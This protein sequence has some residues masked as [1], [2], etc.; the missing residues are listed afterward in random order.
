MP[1]VSLEQAS[2]ARVWASRRR[3]Q[4]GLLRTAGSFAQPLGS[5]IDPDGVAGYYVDMRGKAETE[6]WPPDW[7]CRHEEQEYVAVSQLGLGCYERF[8]GGEGDVWLDGALK[9]GD[10]LLSQQRPGGGWP[11][12][13]AYPHTYWV[14]PPWVSAMAQGEAASLL[15]RLHRETGE[16][17]YAEA[18]QL[19]LRPLWVATVN[20]GVRAE[21]DGGPFLEE[22]PTQPPS[23]ILN[24]T[25]FALWGCRDV[26]VAL[27][28]EDALELFREGHATLAR[29][30]H[31]WDTGY[32]SRYDLYPHP[33]V[34]LANPFY[35]QLHI[36]QLTAM[37]MIAPHRAFAEAHD[38]FEAYARSPVDFARA[39]A[40]KLAFRFVSPRSRRV[41]R[42]FPWARHPARSAVDQRA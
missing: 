32:W 40:S 42:W 26:G 20:G 17:R 38:R 22:T 11:H 36:T 16:D 25:L 21:L 6:R 13:W 23:L 2:R 19:A 31:R 15:V 24:G 1:D 5:R 37:Q 30:I 3:V 35:H 12:L 28:D 41:A 39:Y 10:Y 4:A 14:T 8:L 7:W 29:N 27:G 18:A 33:V 34:N 9:T